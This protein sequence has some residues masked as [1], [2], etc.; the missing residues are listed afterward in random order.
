MRCTQ[1][2]VLRS[3][4]VFFKTFPKL[5]LGLSEAACGFVRSCIYI[6]RKLNVYLSQALYISFQ[7]L[8]V[9][10]SKAECGFVEAAPVF[11]SSCMW[12]FQKLHNDL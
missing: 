3:R 5:H 7:K 8:D 6:F 10:L 4:Y 9:G 12:I 2:S 1:G 11:F